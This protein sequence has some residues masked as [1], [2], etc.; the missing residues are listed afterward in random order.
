MCGEIRCLCLGLEVGEY[1]YC[2]HLRPFIPH[3]SYKTKEKYTEKLEHQKDGKAVC[4]VRSGRT[5][6]RGGAHKKKGC[7]V[8][9]S[10]IVTNI[11]T[12]SF[13]V[14]LTYTHLF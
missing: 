2:Y 14:F 6:Q 10:V 13:I 3:E 8:T 5:R 11:V 12:S 1:D 4:V 7:E 9:C